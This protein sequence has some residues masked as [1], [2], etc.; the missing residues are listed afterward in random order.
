MEYHGASQLAAFAAI[1]AETARQTRREVL[2][3][4]KQKG[5]LPLRSGNAAGHEP[6]QARNGLPALVDLY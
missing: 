6:G 4:V 3:Q 1:E 2:E 5:M